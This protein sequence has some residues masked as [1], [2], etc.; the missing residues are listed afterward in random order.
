M[1]HTAFYFFVRHALVTPAKARGRLWRGV[2]L[3]LCWMLLQIRC[4]NYY[5]I[6][7]S[8]LPSL[9]LPLVCCIE[10]ARCLCH[11]YPVAVRKR[12]EA[13]QIARCSYAMLHTQSAEKRSR[14]KEQRKQLGASKAALDLSA[15]QKYIL[16]LHIYISP[17]LSPSFSLSLNLCAF[18][19]SAFSLCCFVILSCF[20]IFLLWVKRWRPLA[21]ASMYLPLPPT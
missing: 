12:L 9:L 16:Y 21:F 13:A 10:F 4:N 18:L 17:S 6:F 7:A 8:T 11:A 15:T 3:V 19:L 5:H 14:R 20:L 1:L 2:C